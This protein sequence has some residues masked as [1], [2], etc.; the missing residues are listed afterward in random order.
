MA[1][2]NKQYKYLSVFITAFVACY[3]TQ[4]GS[5][6]SF[7]CKVPFQKPILRFASWAEAFTKNKSE[8][9]RVIPLLK[10][11]FLVLIYI[12]KLIPC[13]NGKLVP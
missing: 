9:I 2:E 5:V 11:I 6:K 4:G 10:M 1:V 12:V 7:N 13:A 3:M 8:I